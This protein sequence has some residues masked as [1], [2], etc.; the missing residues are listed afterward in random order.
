MEIVNLS[1]DNENKEY[2]RINKPIKLFT[3]KKH[4]I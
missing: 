3:M 2:K 4:I 1:N